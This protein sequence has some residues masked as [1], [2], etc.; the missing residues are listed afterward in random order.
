MSSKFSLLFFLIISVPLLAQPDIKIIS[1]DRNSIVIDYTP[2]YIDSTAI[3]INNQDYIKY[4]LKFGFVPN[5]EKWG[6]PLI[7]VRSLNIGVPSETGNT[8]QVINSSFK[9]I[10]GSL[11]PKPKSVK[12][13][14]EIDYVYETGKNYSVPAS[15]PDIIKYG[16]YGLMRSVPVQSIIIS[17][18]EYNASQRTIKLYTKIRFRISFSGSQVMASKPAEDIIKG[19]IVN[20]DAAKYWTTK[21]ALGTALKKTGSA[22]SS[23]LSSGTWYRFEAPTE[24]IY[25]I[26]K[27]MLTSYGIDPTTVDPRTIKIYNNGGK[28]L[29]ESLTVARPADLVENAIL[30][31]GGNG[32]T[33]EDGGI[34]YSMAEGMTFGIRYN[35][36]VFKRDHH[37]Y[38]PSYIGA[39][40]PFPPR[41]SVQPHSPHKLAVRTL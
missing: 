38:T 21:S 31:V 11:A 4:G 15:E 16:R 25:M 2:S 39:Q 19:A 23:V 40:L 13:G 3:K 32:S 34:Y 5:P 33:L 37:P 12:N 7:P 41:S 17:P 20:F 26:T 6:E 1:S 29:P 8:I 28:V 24:G 35:Y 14:K 36:H 22:A 18:I 10:Q 30:V 27:S 9:T